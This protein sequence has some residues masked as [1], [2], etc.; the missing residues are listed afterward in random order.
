MIKASAV[1]DINTNTVYT[2][3]RHC[4][5]FSDLKRLNIKPP[6]YHNK[7]FIQGFIDETNKFLT[8]K[9]ALDHAM[10]CGQIKLKKDGSCDIIGG[11]LTSED[12]WQN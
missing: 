3:V 1:L 2:G 12:L 4:E 11:E 9:E 7:G 10:H 6:Y 5:I 8:R